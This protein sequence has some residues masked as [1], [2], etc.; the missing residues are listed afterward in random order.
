MKKGKIRRLASM[1]KDEIAKELEK[2]DRMISS[3]L[4]MCLWKGGS[5]VS[6]KIK[7]IKAAPAARKKIAR[8]NWEMSLLF[9]RNE[10]K[11]RV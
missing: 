5:R 2:T 8:L 1:R 10:L 3:P 6:R 11:R 7:R 4:P 9:Y